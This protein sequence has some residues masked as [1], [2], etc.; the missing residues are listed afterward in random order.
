M[1]PLREFRVNARVARSNRIY[2]SS[3]ARRRGRS[4]GAASGRLDKGIA[5]AG[6]TLVVAVV[7]AGAGPTRSPGRR[8]RADV[9]ETLVFAPCRADATDEVMGTRRA[10]GA[11]TRVAL[12]SARPRS[13]KGATTRVAPRSRRLQFP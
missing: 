6:A 3:G 10:N 8:G 9:G 13:N 2:T 5:R 7:P 1:M 12:T 4:F 11:T